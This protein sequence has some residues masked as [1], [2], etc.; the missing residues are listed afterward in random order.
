[1]KTRQP[2]SRRRGQ[3]IEPPRSPHGYAARHADKAG[4]F[5]QARRDLESEEVFT[6]EYLR[7]TDLHHALRAY[8]QRRR[9]Y[10]SHRIKCG[11]KDIS[12]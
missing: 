11:T 1:M 8:D 9:Q 7:A 3:S 10:R 4:G 5:D 2:D 6:G 12:E